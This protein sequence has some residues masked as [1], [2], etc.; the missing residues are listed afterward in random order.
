MRLKA[1]AKLWMCTGGI[2]LAGLTAPAGATINVDGTL[3]ESDYGASAPG[4]SALNS[5]S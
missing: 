5:L 4:T 1:S 2:L 3:N